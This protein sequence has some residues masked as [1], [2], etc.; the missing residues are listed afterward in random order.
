MDLQFTPEEEAFRLKIRGWLAEN[1][2]TSGLSADREGRDDKTWLAK[3][4]AWQRKLY[5]GGVIA[6]AWPKEYGGQQMDPIRQSIVNDEMVR[7]QAP[8]LV[9]GSGLGMLGPTLISWG[10]EE[11]K[12]RYLPKILTAEEIWC[13]GY[14]EPGAGSDLASLK[15]RADIVGDEFV[16][17]GQKVWTSGAHYADM[18]FCLVRTDPEA[19]KHRGISYVLIDMRSPGIT[20]RPLIQMTGAHSFNEVFFDSVRVPR[21]NLVGKLNEGW[22]VANATLFHERNMLGSATG[23]HQIFNRLLA[24]ARSIRRNRRTLADDPVFRQRLADLEIRV[25][26]MRFHSYRQLSD[27]IHGRNPG[28]ESMINKLVGTELNHDLAT[29]AMELMGDYSML[30]R[31]DEYALD[32]AYWP[33]ES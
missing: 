12:K 2:P 15:T 7:A 22:I 24:L 9:G 18:M 1:M 3:A 6:L 14:S 19:P 23:S 4:K 16:I 25:T 33:Y 21:K 13:Q 32:H 30:A 10:T 17:N 31:G 8:Y 11:Q 28:I 27:Q 29:A 20:V 5:E 26:A